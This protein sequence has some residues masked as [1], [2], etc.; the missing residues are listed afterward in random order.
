MHKGLGFALIGG[1]LV[2]GFALGQYVS[3]GKN[4][5]SD[6]LEHA[7]PA[8]AD[9]AG[10]VD[11]KKVPATG[12]MRG[13]ADALV[14]IVEFSD[15]QCPFCGARRADREAD[16]EGLRRARCASSSGTTRCRSTRTRRWPPRPRWPPTSRASSGRCTTSSSP[17]SRRSSGPTSR[18]T[19]RSSASTWRSSRQ[20]LD[21]SPY[22]AAVDADTA[23][24][25]QGRRATAR[26]A[27]FIN[28]RQLSGAQPFEK[29]KAVID[30]ELANADKLRRARRTPKDKVYAKLHGG[31]RPAAPRR[32][33]R[34]RDPPRRPEVY[35][36][37][38]GD[39]PS[40]GGKSAKVT[41]VEFSDFQCPFC[42][43]RRADAEADRGDLR[44][45]RAGRV[46]STAAAVPQQRAARRRGRRW[47]RS[48]QGKFWEMHDK[49]FA[50]QQALD[51]A[52]LEKYA[53]EIGL[54]MAKF[55]AALDS[56]KCKERIEA[57]Q[58]AGGR[59]SARAARRP[60]SSTAAASSARS[61]STRSRRSSTRS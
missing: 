9:S 12:E 37:A 24:G 21:T 44:Q 38:V 7:G 29:F 41:I 6:T 16:H 15:F 48:E 25:G 13:A 28:G 61:R 27:F 23:L 50:N 26:P 47:P 1:V 18:S 53:E 45:R 8:V 52:D 30:E 32:P 19:R 54:D 4:E 39:A 46:R 34:R 36:V 17:T 35:K 51:R 49:L 33:P 11:R 20:A 42:S 57:D 3:K 56:G 55:K 5:K 43:A 40:K 59:S 10:K 58:D 14:T 22:K 60:S 2:G 31:R